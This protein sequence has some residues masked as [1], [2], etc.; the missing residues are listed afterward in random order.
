MAQNRQ[1]VTEYYQALRSSALQKA[2]ETY[3]LAR[4]NDDF[5]KVDNALSLIE[6]DLAYAEIESDKTKYSSL[7]KQKKN[8]LAERKQILSSMGLKEDD[9]QPKYSCKKCKDTGFVGMEKCDCFAKVLATLTL[10]NTGIKKSHLP[11]FDKHEIKDNKALLQAHEKMKTFVSKF[12]EVKKQNVVFIGGTGTGK[13][14]LAGCVARALSD[15]GF[16]TIMLTSFALNNVFIEYHNLF[17]QGRSEKMDAIINCDLLVI[18]DLGAEQNIK[19]ITSN[20]LLNVLSERNAEKRSTIIT[21]N[22]TGE[23]IINVYH[24]RI[25]SRIFDKSLTAVMS[26]TGKDLRLK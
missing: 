25:Y 2:E 22:L 4:Q 3:V 13:T 9:L 21:T 6:R 19:N 15:K 7:E 1:T 11:E 18:D 24:E 26:F 23:E 16:N 12:P 5:R 8:L 17:N 20:Y 10:S 14:Y